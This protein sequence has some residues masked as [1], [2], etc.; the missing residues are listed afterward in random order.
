LFLRREFQRLSAV[1]D[2][3]ALL[4]ESRQPWLDEETLKAK[5]FALS[6]SVHPDRVHDLPERERK[7][8]QERYTELNAAYNCLRVP[9]DRLRHLL[10]LET[11]RKPAQVQQVPPELVDLFFEIGQA[12]RA[13]DE[14]LKRKA[15]VTSPLL[16]VGLFDEGQNISERLIALRDNLTA[17]QTQHANECREL[18]DQWQQKLDRLEQ[19]QQTLSYLHRW[20]AQLQERIVQLAL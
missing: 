11:G 14:F 5:F 2:Y 3:F 7:A 19:I 17:R 1:T 10:E 8:T 6:T 16:M 15:L 20:T 4:D 18:K 13:A 12:T 9:K